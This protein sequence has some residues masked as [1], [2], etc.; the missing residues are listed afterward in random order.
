MK[1]LNLRVVNVSLGVLCLVGVGLNLLKYIDYQKALG[2]YG[3]TSYLETHLKTIVGSS[4]SESSE[5]STT[6]DES[7]SSSET[8]SS[9]SLSSIQEGDFSSVAGTWKTNDGGSWVI[10]SDGT[11]EK[12][13]DFI[14]QSVTDGI[15]LANMTN[16]SGVGHVYPTYFVPSGTTITL[17]G[18]SSVE[19]VDRIVYVNDG[20]PYG[21]KYSIYYPVKDTIPEDSNLELLSIISKVVTNYRADVNSSLSSRQDKIAE[22]FTS[23]TNSTYIE[24]RDYLVNQSA[25]DG[26][27]SYESVTNSVKNL[28][29][30]GDKI[31]FTLNYTITTSYTDGRASSTTQASRNYVLKKVNGNYLIDSF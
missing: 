12:Q 4:S 17:E 25:K 14:V 5:E 1:K 20:D 11:V 15:L 6:T 31:T 13:V 22:N 21:K 23:T 8:S 7:L 29:K 2:K 18:V 16:K 24:V 10:E 26:I 27:K 30:S 3:A 28:Q 19:N 9:M